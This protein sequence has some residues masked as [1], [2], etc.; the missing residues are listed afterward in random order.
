MTKFTNTEVKT[1]FDAIA[2]TVVIQSTSMS[3]S[4]VAKLNNSFKT[5]GLSNEQIATALVQFHSNAYA[6]DVDAVVKL[7]IEA[8][9]SQVNSEAVQGKKFLIEKQLKLIHEQTNS[10]LIK[11]AQVKRDI[12]SMDD[13]LKVKKAE[14]KANVTAFA[15]NSGSSTAASLVAELNTNID[16]LTPYSTGSASVL[17]PNLPSYVTPTYEA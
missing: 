5:F 13:G 10:E 2:D 3:N 6:V 7:T 4:R 11:Q 16:A 8:L 12:Y 9:N 15:V 17:I 14:Y 1:E